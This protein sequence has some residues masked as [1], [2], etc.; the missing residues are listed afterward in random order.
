M[1]IMVV[2]IV[3]DLLYVDQ[4]FGLVIGILFDAVTKPAEK[5]WFKYHSAILSVML[6]PF[7]VFQF[8][9]VFV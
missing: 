1:I 8:P 6:S 2:G 5:H 9:F 3:E 7:K 4:Q